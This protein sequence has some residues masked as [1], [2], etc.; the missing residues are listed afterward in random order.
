M[1]EDLA[2]NDLA[3]ISNLA[4]TNRTKRSELPLNVN[5]AGVDG[6]TITLAFD[7]SLST[8]PNTGTFRVT[9]NGKAIKVTAIKLKPANREALLTLQSPV[10]FGDSVALSSQGNQK[11]A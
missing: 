11:S 6:D 2:G 4:V 1:I 5:S 3:S 10:A 9:A 7:R 8:T